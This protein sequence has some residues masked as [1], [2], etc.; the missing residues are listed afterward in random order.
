MRYILS[1]LV[2]FLMIE[3]L[4]HKW[5]IISFKMVKRALQIWRKWVIGRRIRV[6]LHFKWDSQKFGLSIQKCNRK[7]CRKV[8]EWKWFYLPSYIESHQWVKNHFFVQLLVSYLQSRPLLSEC[9]KKTLDFCLCHCAKYTLANYV[10]ISAKSLQCLLPV[11]RS[12]SRCF[13]IK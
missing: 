1:Y 6:V 10:K 9:G 7:E 4:P 5:S 8:Y 2:S 3:R 13:V 11:N 12:V